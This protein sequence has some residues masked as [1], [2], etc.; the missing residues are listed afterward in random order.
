MSVTLVDDVD[1]ICKR[2]ESEIPDLNKIDLSPS[3]YYKSLPLCVIDSVF[4][5]Q[6]KYDPTVLNVVQRWCDKQQPQW[7]KWMRDDQIGEYKINDFL[8]IVDGHSYEDLAIN[9]FKNKGRTSSRSGILKAE[10]VVR[11]CNALSINGINDFTDIEDS[12]KLNL[13]E[14]DIKKIEGQKSGITFSYFLMLA[15]SD[16]SMKPDTWIIRFIADVL[17][18]NQLQVNKELAVTLITACFENLKN[19]YD[20]LTLRKL[21]HALWKYQKNKI[22]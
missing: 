3:F 7:Q 13:A 8:R 18:V 14:F 6:S 19:K 1:L 11:F 4:S 2:I 20:S 9:F 22:S 12:K 5:I 16:S 17:N 21:D 10:A 15:G